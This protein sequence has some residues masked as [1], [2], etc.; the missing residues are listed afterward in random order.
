MDGVELGPWVCEGNTNGN[1]K[2][3]RKNWFGK[4]IKFRSEPH[5][6]KLEVDQ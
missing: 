5:R 3:T 6:H 2:D 1:G 4:M